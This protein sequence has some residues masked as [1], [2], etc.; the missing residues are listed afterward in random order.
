MTA[1]AAL[2]IS[3]SEQVRRRQLVL[4]KRRASALLAIVTAVFLAVTVWGGTSGWAAYV[5]ATAAAS[6]VGGLAD[7][8]AVTALFRRPLGL[9]IPHTAIVVER[10]DQFAKTLGEFIQ[11]SFLTPDL[12]IE[13]VRGARVVDSVAGWLADPAH[14]ARTA[15]EVA[16]AVVAVTDLLHDED[17][18]QAI[19]GWLHQVVDSV[20]LAPLAGHAIR[21]VTNNGEL[22]LLVDKVLRGLNAYIEENRDELRQHLSKRSRR[23][24]PSVVDHK[25]FDRVLDGVSSVLKQME[26]DRDH[27]LRRQLQTRVAQLTIDLETSP[28][29]LERGEK[30]KQEILARPEVREWIAGLWA[31]IRRHLQVQASD[32]KSTLQQRIMTMIIGLGRRLQDDQALRAKVEGSVESAVSYVAEHFNGEIS[33]M[34][35]STIA[36]WNAEETAG[37][38]ELL[39]G[40]DL[41]YVRINGTVMG[42]AAGLLLHAV[43]RLLA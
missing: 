32:P 41:Q 19:E 29:F 14:A 33:Q 8:F 21:L 36:R 4:T 26:A 3:R 1:T 24:I 16:D 22:D 23:W 20:P 39:L 40:P 9:P 42:A 43:A 17:V 25:L 30:I 2:P 7:W 15:G 10:K 38:L 6:M 27:D 5:Q 34:V 28:K 11:E 18:H 35:T 37:R 13:R 31:D 12:I